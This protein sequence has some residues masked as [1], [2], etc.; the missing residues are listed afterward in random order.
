MRV[1]RI[2]PYEIRYNGDSIDEIVGPGIHLEYMDDNHVWMA[3][4]ER[5]KKYPTLHVNLYHPKAH[6]GCTAEDVRWPR[7]TK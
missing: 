2:G 6:I 5:G 4:N 1:E 3:L 7:R